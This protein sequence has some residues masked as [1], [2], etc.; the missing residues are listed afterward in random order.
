MRSWQ[1]ELK[2]FQ[3]SYDPDY[4]AKSAD[5]QWRARTGKNVY[6]SRN[7]PCELH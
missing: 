3:E 5:L 4:D 2:R 6:S 1:P 7:S